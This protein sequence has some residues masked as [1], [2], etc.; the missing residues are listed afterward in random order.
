MLLQWSENI[1]RSS[2]DLDIDLENEKADGE[3]LR[4]SMTKD[5]REPSA[6]PTNSNE[7]ADGEKLRHSTTK[8]AEELRAA[9]TNSDEEADGEKL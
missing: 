7:E 3:K 4:R 1:C 9:P 6:A 8:D 2:I 5:A